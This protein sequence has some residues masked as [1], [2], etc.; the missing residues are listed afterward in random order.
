MIL[1][2][3]KNDIRV[4]CAESGETQTSV[5]YRLGTTGQY[6]NKLTNGNVNMVNKMF[7]RMMEQLG[8]DIRIEYVRKESSR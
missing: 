8:Y 2:N 7:V 4:K 3:F 5:A 6:I 1:N